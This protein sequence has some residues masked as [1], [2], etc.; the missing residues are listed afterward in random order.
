HP[1][2]KSRARAHRRAR[3]SERREDALE[4]AAGAGRMLSARGDSPR[5]PAT[6][7]G[8][9]DRRRNR[10]LEYSF[11]EAPSDSSRM[12]T[13]N[14]IFPSILPRLAGSSSEKMA[15]EPRRYSFV[16]ECAMHRRLVGLLV[17]AAAISVLALG[18]TSALRAADHPHVAPPESRPHGM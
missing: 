11:S 12:M 18:T 17:T 13:T 16:R 4:R 6:V 9:Q 3:A 1:I 10:R 7:A 2:R 14:H 8:S 15:F 5:V